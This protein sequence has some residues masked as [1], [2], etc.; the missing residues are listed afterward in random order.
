ME[1]TIE[2]MPNYALAGVDNTRV[3]RMILI[4]IDTEK[5]KACFIMSHSGRANVYISIHEVPT[6]LLPS[7]RL[8]EALL[9]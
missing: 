4:N 8:N 5:R 1:E 7:S 2:I 9:T 6:Y 3:G